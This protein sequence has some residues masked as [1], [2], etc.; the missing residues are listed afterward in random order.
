MITNS[1]IARRSGLKR[2]RSKLL[3]GLL[4]SFQSLPADPFLKRQAGLAMTQ[5]AVIAMTA[6]LCTTGAPPCF[7][8]AP[9][10][11]SSLSSF[12]KIPVL[13]DGRIKPL[14]TYAQNVLLQLSGKRTFDKKPAIIWLSKIIFEPETTHD[15][16][17]FLINNPETVQ[18]LKLQEQPARRYSFSQLESSYHQLATLAQKASQ[19][20]D[21]KRSL[22][23]N[24]LMHTYGN[25]EFYLSLVHSMQFAIAHS[26]F[27]ISNAQTLKTLGLGSEEKDFSFLDVALA[28]DRIEPM[29]ESFE[30]KNPQSWNPFEK[31]VFRILSNLYQ[32]SMIYQNMPLEIMA[33]LNPEHEMWLGPWDAIRLG[34]KNAAIRG[35]LATLKEM[36][37][38]YR[39][40]RANDFELASKSFLKSIFERAG[41]KRALKFLSL[42]IFNNDLK[43]FWIAQLFYLL[44]FIFIILALVRESALLSRFAFGLVLLGF[45][46]HAFGLASRIIILGRPPISSLYETFIFVSFIAVILGLIIES[47]MRNR[48]GTV[49]AAF[50]GTVLLIISSG[51]S[52]DGDTLKVLVA[53]LNSNFWLGIHVPN[54]TMGY[55]ACCVAGLIGHMYLIQAILNPSDKKQLARTMNLMLGILGLG[56]TLSFFGTML[57]GIWAD[58]SWGR[59]WGWDPKENGALMIVLWCAIVFHARIA[60]F[61]GALGTAIGCSL[62][63]CIVAWAWFGV[64]LLSVGLHSY[65][66]T[67]GVA[68]GFITFIVGELLFITTAGILAYRNSK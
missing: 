8:G 45:A 50:S 55:A 14:D 35:E 1:V 41:Q 36:T 63:L 18:A 47:L 68:Q 17:I 59:F 37:A 43:P 13:Q 2:R 22:V 26:D 19:I 48:L 20:E 4:R 44:A 21:K 5:F 31:D 33:P 58:Q 24:E 23:D 60:K 25:V 42:E 15:D 40:G 52:T 53:V 64:N 3:K 9:L 38:A 39:E 67:S 65:G 61:I 7:G 12:R 29:T 66:F 54:I 57:G 16:K 62:L 46:P 28:A 56:L 51:F 11:L 30:R 27:H 6:L 34:F 49:I 10:N 32:W